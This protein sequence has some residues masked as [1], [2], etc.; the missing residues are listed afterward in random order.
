MITGAG[1]GI[2]AAGARL[3]AAHGLEVVL[4]G[5]R[6]EPLEAVREELGGRALVD[7]RGHRRACDAER[8]VERTLA[9]FG[10]LDVIVNNA[11][12]IEPGPI[13]RVTREAFERHYAV[14]VAGPFFLVTAALGALRASAMRRS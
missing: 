11:A 3:F 1:T 4:V 12:V 14:N 2:G 8:I 7:R 10:Q 6:P 5:R 9:E 13:D